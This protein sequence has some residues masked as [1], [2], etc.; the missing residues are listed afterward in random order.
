MTSSS[1]SAQVTVSSPS[2]T[3]CASDS[4]SVPSAPRTGAIPAVSSLIERS[5]DRSV[6]RMS[7]QPRRGEYPGARCRISEM[8][9]MRQCKSYTRCHDSIRWSS[10]FPSEPRAAGIEFRRRERVPTVP[11]NSLAGAI[12]ADDSSWATTSSPILACA[13]S[14]YAETQYGCMARARMSKSWLEHAPSSTPLMSRSARAFSGRPRTSK[15]SGPKKSNSTHGVASPGSWLL[16]LMS[17][18]QMEAGVDSTRVLSMALPATT[19]LTKH[20]CPGGHASE[21]QAIVDSLSRISRCSASEVSR[22]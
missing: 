22:R 20:C 12:G 6:S 3:P 2:P 14:S 11:A 21:V 19:T 17:W 16:E 4:A 18:P 1:N 15:A 7:K 8:T 9:L 5:P 10:S 13:C